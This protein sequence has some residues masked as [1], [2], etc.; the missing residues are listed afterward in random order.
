MLRH[1]D[2]TTEV[3]DLPGGI[4][5][6][7]DADAAYPVTELHLAP[8][9]M[10]ALYTDGMVEQSGTDIDVGIER[11]RRTIADFGPAPLADTA[12]HVIGRARQ[13]PD[14]PDDIALL[15]A[16]RWDDADGGTAPTPRAAGTGRPADGFGT[17]PP[18]TAEEQG[19]E[20]EG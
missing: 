8:G 19:E 16:A 18:A 13:A 6:G 15:L 10:L 20:R 7:V 14:R 5:L 3:M 4:V 1:P 12:E 11:L 2:G 17:A 9:A